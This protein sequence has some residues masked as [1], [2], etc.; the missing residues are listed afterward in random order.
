MFHSFPDIGDIRYK[1]KNF[2]IYFLSRFL[3]N[4]DDDDDRK[5]VIF[6]KFQLHL[7]LN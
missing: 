5:Y 1:Y 6:L 3:K 4:H 7:R 2:V